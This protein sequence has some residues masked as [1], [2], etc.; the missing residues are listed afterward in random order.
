MNSGSSLLFLVGDFGATL[1][2]VLEKYAPDRMSLSHQ[3]LESFD[4]IK[5][6]LGEEE[7]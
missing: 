3:E 7:K 2:E 4:V 6:V 1:A 5:A